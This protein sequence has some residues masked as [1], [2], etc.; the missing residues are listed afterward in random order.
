MLCDSFNDELQ[1][2]STGDMLMEY[3]IMSGLTAVII[4]LLYAVVKQKQQE[5]A[6]W[7][8]RKASK[9]QAKKVK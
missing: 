2:L 4:G 5:T 7:K 3:L 8:K 9:A 1:R 6:E